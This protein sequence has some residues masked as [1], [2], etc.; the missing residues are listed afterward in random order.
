ML[1][2]TLLGIPHESLPHDK[3]WRYH[4]PSPHKVVDSV[5]SSVKLRR[6]FLQ[7][8]ADKL[9]ELDGTIKGTYKT[10]LCITLPLLSQSRIEIC[11][12]D[13]YR[14]KLI[15]RTDAPSEWSPMRDDRNIVK[16]L[17]IALP[18]E[19]SARGY[20]RNQTDAKRRDLEENWFIWKVTAR[21]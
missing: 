20:S 11:V 12:D 18:A 8:L 17:N 16:E 10:L 21:A 13:K 4:V 2:S 5:N 3:S 1:D 19:Y 7:L 6:K 15:D 9:V 14:E